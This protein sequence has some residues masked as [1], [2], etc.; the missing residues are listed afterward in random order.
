MVIAGDI[1]SKN[2]FLGIFHE[3]EKGTPVLA[4]SPNSL[5]KWSTTDYDNLES[6]VEAFLQQSG[7]EEPICAACF[8]I[9]GPV[10][11]GIGHIVTKE[12]KWDISEDNLC[13]FLIKQSWKKNECE[14]AKEQRIVRV[15][16]SLEGID[17]NGL[18][19]SDKI[20]ELNQSNTTEQTATEHQRCALLGIRESVGEALIHWGHLSNGDEGY[21]VSF[22]EGG[23]CYFAPGSK[24]EVKFLNYLLKHPENLDHPEIVTYQNVLSRKGIVFIY[25]F[26]QEE[27]K[28]KTTVDGLEELLKQE[29]FEEAAG[30]IMIAA[31]NEEDAVCEKA[32]D[33][34]FSIY[35]AEAS[36]LALKYYAKG[37]IYYLRGALILPELMD[38][39]LMDKLINK[40][41]ATFMP[42]FTRR[43]KPAV[44]E[45]LESIPVKLVNYPDIRLYGAARL[46]LDKEHIG[47]ILRD[48]CE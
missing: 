46:A 3:D 15:I 37:G 34:F 19:K 36:N 5:V 10:N 7:L 48:R 39:K 17:F 24:E 8:G 18:L 47:C 35:G 29:E 33:L 22:S 41:K 4:K 44:R 31:L 38:N 16:N 25:Q 32:I 30:K 43:A 2:S 27:M 21:V 12:S 28:A 45:L 42:A 20:T 11:N 23:H 14:A 6:L 9:S 1:G 13:D 26:V 40:L